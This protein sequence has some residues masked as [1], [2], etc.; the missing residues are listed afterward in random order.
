MKVRAYMLHTHMSKKTHTHANCVVA[1]YSLSNEYIDVSSIGSTMQC[2]FLFEARHLCVRQSMFTYGLNRSIKSMLQ[3]GPNTYIS[4]GHSPL[5][6][7]LCAQC[8]LYSID[9]VK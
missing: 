7:T 1:Y 4:N 3:P 9:G 6:Y 2:I 8:I 5:I